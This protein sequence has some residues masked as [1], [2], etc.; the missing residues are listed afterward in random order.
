VP[1]DARQEARYKLFVL[2]RELRNALACFKRLDATPAL[3]PSAY[4][5]EWF[6]PASALELLHFHSLV[7]GYEQPTCYA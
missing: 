1:A 5:R 4:G 6:A 3:G 2:E 7:D